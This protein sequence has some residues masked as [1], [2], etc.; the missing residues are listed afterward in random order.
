MIPYKM[1]NRWEVSSDSCK[2]IANDFVPA[3]RLE[4]ISEIT[5]KVEKLTVIIQ[6]HLKNAKANYPYLSI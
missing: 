2:K 1:L 6:Q 4:D 3:Q 5:D